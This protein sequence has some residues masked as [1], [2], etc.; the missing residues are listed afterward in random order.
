MGR[1]VGDGGIYFYVQDVIVVPEWQR[2]GIGSEIMNA[3]MAFVGSNAS[4]GAFV[5]LMAAR[6]AAQ[7]Y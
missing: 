1:V 7:F 3:I 2:R 5:G 4:P 6:G